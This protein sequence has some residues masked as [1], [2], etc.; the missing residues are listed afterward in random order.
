VLRLVLAEGALQALAGVIDAALGGEVGGANR[1]V[2]LL[3]NG[4]GHLAGHVL[5]TGDLEGARLHLLRVEL[6]GD[7][8]RELGPRRR[9]EHGDLLATGE[10]DG[11]AVRGDGGQRHAHASLIHAR[12]SLAAR[13]GCSSTLATT[14]S[15]MTVLM[16]GIV[17][18]ISNGSGGGGGSGGFESSSIF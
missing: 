4:I 13:F 9:A 8:A 18:L 16:I 5:Q 10:L 12:T 6:P 3:Q 2:P 15:R 7:L 17:R 14:R 11:D 1:L